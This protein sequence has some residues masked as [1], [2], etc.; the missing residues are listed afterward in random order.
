MTTRA[1][2]LSAF[3]VESS[4][5][6]RTRATVASGPALQGPGQTGLIDGGG[7][8]SVDLGPTLVGNDADDPTSE[9]D[10]RAVMFNADFGL[11]RFEVPCTE[12]AV[13][14]RTATISA[15]LPL[16][17]TALSLALTDGDPDVEAGELFSIV[18]ASTLVRLYAVA[19][20]AASVDGV[21]AITVRPPLREPTAATTALDFANPRCYMRLIDPRGEAWGQF[22]ENYMAS[23][24]APML[25]E[26]FD[27][28]TAADPGDSDDGGMG[29]GG[30]G[31]AF[32]CEAV[33]FDGATALT[34]TALLTAGQK[35]AFSV[36]VRMTTAPTGYA[37]YVWATETDDVERQLIG[38][39]MGP[40]G[41]DTD[42][43]LIAGNADLTL[44][45]LSLA[46][47]F[48]I[49]NSVW[50][51]IVGSADSSAGKIAIAIDGAV[52]N[53]TTGAGTL[54]FD[55]AETILIGTESTGAGEY[56]TGDMAEF[57][58]ETGVSLL[59]GAGSFDAATLEKF[60]DP[61]TGKAVDLGTDGSTPTGTAPGVYLS[62]RSGDAVAAFLTNRGTG[63]AFTAET[64][65]L[66]SAAT[67]P[68]S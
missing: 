46:S 57:W 33:T 64:G 17:A 14:S 21:Q 43:Q 5:W 6:K 15:D 65:A 42:I 58:L 61:S 27:P 34:G 63:G 68:T 50:R 13:L 54:D 8:W 9:R 56:F 11:G 60:R 52:V 24:K 62:R 18:H 66:T 39:G 32:V 20:A 22:S 44:E 2:P 3:P 16:R 40:D 19:T 48:D 51:N 47:A 38:L 28:P 45:Y 35:F 41:S 30:G 49:A 7:W 59:N 53:A 55:L 12:E 31:G 4:Q 23:P 10:W 1:W 37:G 29:D 67:S 25:V 26:A 36:W